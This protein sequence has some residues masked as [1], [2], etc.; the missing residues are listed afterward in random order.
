MRR[1]VSS[2]LEFAKGR[3]TFSFW[4]FLAPL[5][6]I[7]RLI[8]SL[9]NFCYDH[10]I[11]IS[12]E[13]PVP[14]ISVG[15][16]TLG[17][18]NK[19]PFVEML[20][21]ELSGRGIKT[22]IITR[23][24]GGKVSEPV[25]I[26]N[27]MSTRALVGDEPLLLSSRLENVPVAVSRD[28]LKDVQALKEEGVDLV[29][30]DDCFQHRKLG[31]DVDIVLID[32]TCPFGNGFFTPA[33]ILRESPRSIS[34][35]HMVVITKTDQVTEDRIAEIREKV[36][37]YIEMDHIFSSR[38]ELSSWCFWNEGW[39]PVPQQEV[40]QGK[41]IAFS[42]IGNPESLK[43]FL[44]K[45]NIEIRS[46]H[47]F[48][49][50]HRFTHREMELLQ[51]EAET[52]GA[53]GLLCTEK[54]I[55]NLPAGLKGSLR[56]VVPR[57]RAVVEE[58]ERFF[59][60]LVSCLRPNV[61]V[62][63][64]GYGEDAIGSILAEH[65]ARR[66]KG[67]SVRAF[68]V[69]GQGMDYSKRGIPVVENPF[70]SPTGGVIKYSIRDLVM[71]IRAGLLKNIS[72]QL[73]IWRNFRGKFRTVICVGDVYLLLQ[74][75][76]GQ[77]QLPV[78]MATAKTVRLSGHW[79]LER[80]LLRHRCRRVWTRDEETAG[81]MISNNVD[82]VYS[83]NPIMDLLCDNNEGD[84]PWTRDEEISRILLLPGS[85]E[86]AYRDMSLILQT[87]LLLKD[88]IRAEF[89]LVIAPSIRIGRMIRENPGWSFVGDTLQKGNF[90]IRVLKGN[91]VGAAGSA[92]I[93]LGFGG[94]AN[95]LC[96]GM[97][98]PVVSMVEKG[99]NVQKKLLG[100]AESLVPGTPGSLASEIRRIMCSREEYIRMSRAG[101]ERLGAPGA[102]NSLLEYMSSTVGWECR[103]RVYS[104]LAGSTWRSE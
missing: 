70:V 63:S 6:L 74:T 37:R 84:S 93:V 13:P 49:D 67:I 98:K 87:A 34:R 97:G 16:L 48:K 55:H 89:T 56:I 43:I 11:A 47:F 58:R 23:G 44:E 29:V 40:M 31:R 41:W 21:L 73:K 81:E 103:A 59:A 39:R 54:D 99:K 32:A 68:P 96:A 91:L 22:G 66:F 4:L 5:E 88:M 83:G 85:R 14:V 35:S 28:R 2:Y 60:T 26:R 24:Y 71:E 17:G 20:V 95:Q 30:A 64:N 8:V 102:I 19:T 52:E 10:G 53:A 38:L 12:T 69:V 36:S 27:G 50:H 9:R 79:K 82:A 61:M 77:G 94:T 46:Y 62:T 18:T 104:E 72:R 42:A 92:D 75:L 78:L 76:W 51:A 3:K 1:L 57:I 45:R 86:R 100:D 65:L 101:L 90:R 80:F 7:T 25:V 33:G 15:N